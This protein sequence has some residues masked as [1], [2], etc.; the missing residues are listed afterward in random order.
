MQLNKSLESAPAL[1]GPAADG[2]QTG[3]E[4]G[5]ARSTWNEGN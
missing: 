5:R 3:M 2:V 4:G 1:A